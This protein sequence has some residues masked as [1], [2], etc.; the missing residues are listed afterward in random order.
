MPF[1]PCLLL[2]NVSH[3]GNCRRSSG[4][5]PERWLVFCG[6]F[7][8]FRTYYPR[9][10]VLLLDMLDTVPYVP[11]FS[12]LSS[13]EQKPLAATASFYRRNIFTCF[14]RHLIYL[15]F[16]RASLKLIYWIFWVVFMNHK[17]HVSSPTLKQ[18]FLFDKLFTAP[19]F[20]LTERANHHKCG[21]ALGT[22]FNPFG[23]MQLN[24]WRLFFPF[25]LSCENTSKSIS[26]LSLLQCCFPQATKGLILVRR[27]P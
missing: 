19:N 5:A 13:P 22:V 9:S 12:F 21:K 25:M 23:G 24:K 10:T 15:P 4:K 18:V 6:L 17:L 27:Q 7:W 1:L 26:F 14:A 16:C 3:H 8:V 20:P 11:L 2:P